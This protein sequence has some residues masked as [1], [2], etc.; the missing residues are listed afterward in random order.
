MQSL[1]L[2]EGN[3]AGGVY[4]FAAVG[5]N[6]NQNNGKRLSGK[7]GFLG[8]FGRA[9]RTQGT[10]IAMMQWNWDVYLGED[11]QQGR[12]VKPRTR[13]QPTPS[14][15]G[16]VGR[17]IPITGKFGSWEMVPPLET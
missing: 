17:L 9:A 5:V 6:L 2:S 4:D 7:A 12:L 11:C 15:F 1:R 3:E 16:A 14:E 13:L 10:R 8:L